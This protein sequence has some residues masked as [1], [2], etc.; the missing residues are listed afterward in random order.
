[1]EYYGLRVDD[2]EISL[3][4]ADVESVSAVYESLDS[5]APTRRIRLR[6]WSISRY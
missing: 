3:N 1:M 4:V 2:Q 5:G 6:K